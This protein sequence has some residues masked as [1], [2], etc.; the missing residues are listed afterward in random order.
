MIK[1]E[2]QEIALERVRSTLDKL[3]ILQACLQELFDICLEDNDFV[4]SCD[5]KR[6]LSS[7]EDLRPLL[8]QVE[9]SWSYDLLD[10]LADRIFNKVKEIMASLKIVENHCI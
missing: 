6:A 2:D 4:V 1:Q 7:T 5:V 10:K 8:D 3:E 9:S